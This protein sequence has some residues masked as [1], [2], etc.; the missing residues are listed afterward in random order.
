[1]FSFLSAAFSF[2]S[3]NWKDIGKWAGVLVVFCT[4][5]Y[6]VYDYTKAK[7]LAAEGKAIADKWEGNYQQAAK[8]NEENT[9]E[10]NTLKTDFAKLSD[11]LKKREEALVAINDD[12]NNREQRITILERENAEVRAALNYSIPCE[13]W[14][15][16]FP[17]S[18]LC[19]DTNKSNQ[20]DS[21]RKSTTT[22]PTSKGTKY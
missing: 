16:I 21:S 11:I 17:N 22:V 15:E 14:R 5:S 19:L 13:L 9:K 8:I 12:I 6:F 20:A 10:L 3:G 7:E 4:V 2:I 18:A 1:M